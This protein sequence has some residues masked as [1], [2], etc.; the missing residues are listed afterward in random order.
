MF[1][2]ASDLHGVISRVVHGLGG[3]GFF[4]TR[5][6]LVQDWM[7]GFSTSNRPVT[8]KDLL[9]QVADGWWSVSGEHDYHR[10]ASKH[11]EI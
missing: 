3:S 11:G 5:N 10:N 1:E 2:Q 7:G 4:P 8:V 9:I 6:Q